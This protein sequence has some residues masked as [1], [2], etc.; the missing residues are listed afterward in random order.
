M[1][2]LVKTSEGYPVG[3]LFS[4]TS[5]TASVELTQFQATLLA[6]E[7]VN[8]SGG[9]NGIPIKPV[10]LE[11]GPLPANYK[12]AAQHLCDNE[13]VQILFGTH[14]SNT[15]KA[16]LPVVENKNALLFYPTMYEGFE[17][18]TNCFYTGAAPNQSS[19]QLAN[20]VVKNHGNRVLFVGSNY[21]FAHESNR[22]MR[23]LFTQTGGEVVDEVYLDLDSS[24]DAFDDVIRRAVALM[25]DAIYS[26]AVGKD[27]IRLYEAFGRSALLRKAMPIVSLATNEAD[28][29]LM[30]AD[31]A[32]GHI[33]AAPYFESLDTE[34]SRRFVAQYQSRFG[35]GLPLTSGAESA[36]FQVHLFA[37][38]ARKAETLTIDTLI[39]GLGGTSFEAPQGCVKI[40]E[41]SHHT[42][43]WPRIAKVNS[44]RRF[45]ILEEEQHAIQPFPY[46]IQHKIAHGEAQNA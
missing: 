20:H 4:R 7:E 9:I 36:Y 46:M 42:Y 40:D 31:A 27:T 43:L 28:I 23:D 39:D 19:V 26:T 37:Q 6:I 17:F 32:E 35:E 44:A 13:N 18:S 14:M 15:R 25:P 45:E 3:L 38:A 22:I 8:A 33:S 30:S 5:L 10:E 34:Q 16:V 21:I 24:E 12:I 41:A 29:A 1:K 2:P 11:V